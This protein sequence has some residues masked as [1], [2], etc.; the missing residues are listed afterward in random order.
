MPSPISV[1]IE[2][3]SYLKKYLISQSENYKEPLEFAL[4]HE[5]N[6]LLMKLVSNRRDVKRVNKDESCI[7]IKL[8]FN[9]VKNVYFYNNISFHN[10]VL[11]REHVKLDFYYDFRLFVKYQIMKGV[12][13]KIAIE[14]FFELLQINEDDIKFESFYRNFTR[15]NDKK[16]RKVPF[17]AT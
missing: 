8:P 10:R 1:Y 15:Y 16:G 14:Q 3:P 7:K 9:E 2:M 13:R 5:Y 4:N 6:L 11:F 12:Q 17:Y